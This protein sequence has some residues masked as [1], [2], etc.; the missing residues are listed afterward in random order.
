MQKIGLIGLAV[1]G[2]N[3]ALNI[4]EKGFSIAVFNRSIEKVADFVQ[5]HAGKKIYGCKSPEELASVLERPRRILMMVKAGQPVDD[6]IAAVKPYLDK[7]DMLVDGGNEHYTNTVRRAR[8][9]EAE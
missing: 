7:G 4:E 2:E 1:M 9:L 3:L 8:A 6:T 5:R